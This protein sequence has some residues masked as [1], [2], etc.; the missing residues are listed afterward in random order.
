[1][2][3][4][5]AFDLEETRKISWQEEFPKTTKCCR[6]KGNARLGFVAHETQDYKKGNKY[7]SQ[8]YENMKDKKF[9][10]HDC[11]CVAVY[12]CEECLKPTALYNQA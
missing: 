2:K 3:V 4:K 10:L 6:C 1:M 5:I 11:C 8:L 9:W 12:F 7:V